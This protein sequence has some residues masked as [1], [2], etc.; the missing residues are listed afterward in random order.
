[1]KGDISKL[2]HQKKLLTS[3]VESTGL[4]VNFHKSM[5]VPVNVDEVKLDIMSRTLGCTKGKL[6]FT[7]LGL[8]LSL[9]RPTIADY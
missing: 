7:Y 9:T 4:K 3:F 8:L 6:P 1:M 2:N 5:M